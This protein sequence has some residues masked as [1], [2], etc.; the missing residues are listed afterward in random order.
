MGEFKKP[1]DDTKDKFLQDKVS[2]AQQNFRNITKLSIAG[3][4]I[5]PHYQ[6]PLFNK[7]KSSQVE[8][9]KE[10]ISPRT[11]LISDFKPPELE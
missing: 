8:R 4:I 5:C 7:G 6:K 2:E 10:G 3:E 1:V 11:F 9:S